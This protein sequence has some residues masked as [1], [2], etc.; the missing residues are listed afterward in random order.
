MKQ[1][2]IAKNDGIFFVYLLH[3]KTHKIHFCQ[4]EMI[5]ENST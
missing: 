1:M 3:T 4:L 2:T 5:E